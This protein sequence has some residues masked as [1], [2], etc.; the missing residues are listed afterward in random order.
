MDAAASTPSTK[1]AVVT[2]IALLGI[3]LTVF[4]IAGFAFLRPGATEPGWPGLLVLYALA[5]LPGMALGFRYLDTKR[6]KLAFLLGYPIACL[7]LLIIAW[8]MTGCGLTNV[9]L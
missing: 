3:P 7:S 8:L 1:Y 6:T 9:C 5:T 4:V 2:F